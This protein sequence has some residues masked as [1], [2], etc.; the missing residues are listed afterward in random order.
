VRCGSII[1][2]PGKAEVRHHPSA[3]ATTHQRKTCKPPTLSRTSILSGGR[4]KTVSLT[5][6]TAP[7]LTPVS[8][9]RRGTPRPTTSTTQKT[10]K[11]AH[12]VF[13]STAAP[14][15]Y[16]PQQHLTSSPHYPSTHG[17]NHLIHLQRLTVV[18]LS[19]TRLR[20]PENDVAFGWPGLGV[21]MLSPRW[22]LNTL[23]VP[24]WCE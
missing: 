7:T 11:R 18:V 9:L 20:F 23:I 21:Q 22:I 16:P 12:T 14:K 3:P 2:P 5:R 4:T 8:G 6:G 10:S 15:S 1:L 13:S 24:L 17:G 19:S